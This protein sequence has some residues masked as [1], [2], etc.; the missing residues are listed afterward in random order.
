M[1]NAKLKWNH[2]LCGFGRTQSSYPSRSNNWTSND[3]SHLR[4]FYTPSYRLQELPHLTWSIS[5][6]GVS[7]AVSDLEIKDP[8]ET[9][10][11][12]TPNSASATQQS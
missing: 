8:Q 12:V 6:I 3:V 9:K 4:Y 7:C 1:S 2:Q 11:D 10:K 5:N